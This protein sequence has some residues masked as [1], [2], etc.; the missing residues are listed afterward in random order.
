ML[1]EIEMIIAYKFHLLGFNSCPTGKREGACERST[2]V[3]RQWLS[4]RW[5]AHSGRRR[6]AQE[7]DGNHPSWYWSQFKSFSLVM[8]LCLV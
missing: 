7:V 4:Q 3:Q 2:D 8:S 6:E 1:V 5:S